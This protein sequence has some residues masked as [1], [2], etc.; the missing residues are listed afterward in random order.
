MH[1]VCQDMIT[2]EQKSSVLL[3]NSADP[4]KFIQRGGAARLLDISGW[5]KSPLLEEVTKSS[6]SV[7]Q[8]HFNPMQQSNNYTNL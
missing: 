8:D 3:Q 1:D 2:A 6:P 7:Q 5:N 4:T